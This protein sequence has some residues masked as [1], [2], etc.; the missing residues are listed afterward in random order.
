MSPDLAAET[1]DAFGRY[2]QVEYVG[3]GGMA[4]VYKAY[5]ATL[6]RT[7]ALKFLLGESPELSERLLNEARAQ[8][9]IEHENVC[10]IYEAGETDGKLYIAM[11]Y[12]HG[13]TL[14][15]LAP[16]IS[17]EQKIRIVAQTAEAVHAAHRVGLI[18]RDLK[19]A[20]I[21]VERSQEGDLTP[22]VVDFGLARGPEAGGLTKTGTV[23]GSP[24][25][26]SPEQAKGNV[27]QLDRRSDVYSLGAT[28][29]EV[30]AGKPPF[31]AAAG[32]RSHPA[33]FRRSACV[34]SIPPFETG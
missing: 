2:E 18:H 24:W 12:I 1:P 15:K 3:Q 19:P 32:A 21:L 31:E 6:R 17:L 13:K 20:N 29:Y 27:S 9:R 34:G 14:R 22:Y 16:E 10:K 28:L 26:M 25:Y 8:A 33:F 5:D 11:Q 7:V 23:M 4:K 30:L